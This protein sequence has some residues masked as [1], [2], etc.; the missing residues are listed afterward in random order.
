MGFFLGSFMS[1]A[2]PM[3]KYLSGDVPDVTL[4]IGMHQTVNDLTT[5]PLPSDFVEAN[6]P[7]YARIP[8]PRGYPV[9]TL[10]NGLLIYQ[11]DF[12]Q[13]QCQRNFFPAQILRGWIMYANGPF[14]LVR[15]ATWGLFAPPQSVRFN[16]D[17]VTIAAMFSVGQITTPLVNP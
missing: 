9:T 1:E 13:W 6:F 11:D 15:V 10:D 14:D 5:W 16:G 2:F 8:L 7:G 3:F 4:S 12:R 17:L